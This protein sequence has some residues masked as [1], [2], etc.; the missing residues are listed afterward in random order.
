MNQRILVCGG[1]TYSDRAKVY[2]TLDA[3]SP[4]PADNPTLGCWLPQGVTIITGKCPTGADQIAG[5]WAVVNWT[6][7]EEYPVDHTLDGPWPAAGPRR[8]ARMLRES[9][10][11]RVI[12]FFT[13]GQPNRGTPDMCKR[14]AKAG[15]PITRVL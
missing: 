14:A 12:A 13:P 1:R 6:G 10:P 8:N 7:L 5:D 4:E 9:K 11:D 3:L 2:T 15:I